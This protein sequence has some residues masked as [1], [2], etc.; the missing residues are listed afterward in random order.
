MN[1]LLS[2]IQEHLPAPHAHSA[3]ETTEV[4]AHPD[5]NGF[6]N[7][8]WQEDQNMEELENQAREAAEA[9]GDEFVTEGRGEGAVDAEEPEE[10]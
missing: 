5:P 3:D 10:E 2:L 1:G 7:D 6:G 9:E 8:E 4:E